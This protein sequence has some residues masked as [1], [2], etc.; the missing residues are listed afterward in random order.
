MNNWCRRA[1]IFFLS[2]VLVP[3][4]LAQDVTFSTVPM[5]GSATRE[6]VEALIASVSARED[7]DEET[8]TAVLERLQAAR[9]F[10]DNRLASETATADFTASL[11]TAPAET[12]AIR[13]ELDEVIPIE[14]Q[15]QNIP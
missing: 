11:E 1:A 7:L 9:D 8:R 2:S 14:Q 10:A 15:V 6:Q 3:A 5:D 4:V 13:A 12:A